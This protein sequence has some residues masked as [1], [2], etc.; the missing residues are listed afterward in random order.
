MEDNK[1]SILWHEEIL[2]TANQMENLIKCVKS[3]NMLQDGDREEL[4][5]QAIGRMT[6]TVYPAVANPTKYLVKF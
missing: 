5:G 2:K 6:K 3:K 1:E 4:T